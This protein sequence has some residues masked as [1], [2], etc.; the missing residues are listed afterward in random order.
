MIRF[1]I[2]AGVFSKTTRWYKT[3]KGAQS[4]AHFWTGAKPWIEKDPTGQI[5][6][7][8]WCHL[9]PTSVRTEGFSGQWQA[10]WPEGVE[11]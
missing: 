1:H 10:I 9:G 8:G 11:L 3:L 4:A 5:I 2:T 7:T 6:A